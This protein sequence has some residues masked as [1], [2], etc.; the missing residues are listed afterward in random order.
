MYLVIGGLAK[1]YNA[2]DGVTDIF[3][4]RC[5]ASPGRAIDHPV[6]YHREVIVDQLRPL[7]ILQPQSGVR[8]F[9][10]AA[11]TKE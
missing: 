2:A 6:S 9:S 10:C 1:P 3:V 5:L 11:G 8:A 4:A 7:D